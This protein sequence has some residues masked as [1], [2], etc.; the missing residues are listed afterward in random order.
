[1]I[2][3]EAMG[4]VQ[5]GPYQQLLAKGWA[6]YEQPFYSGGRAALTTKPGAQLRA[7]LRDLPAGD[8]EVTVT[9]YNYGAGAN[10]IEIRMAGAV[11]RLRFGGPAKAGDVTPLRCVLPNITPGVLTLEAVGIGQQALIVD[12]VSVRRIR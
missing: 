9:V 6:A 2:E 12:T 8:Y 10:E 1:V 4:G 5:S 11:R 7:N 3:A